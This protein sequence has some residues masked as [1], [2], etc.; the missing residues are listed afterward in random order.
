MLFNLVPGIIAHKEMFENLGFPKHSAMRITSCKGFFLLWACSRVALYLSVENCFVGC[1]LRFFDGP[2]GA[3]IGQRRAKSGTLGVVRHK[4]SFEVL[5]YRHED[6]ILNTGGQ[7]TPLPTG[8]F[9]NKDC[10]SCPQ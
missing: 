4:E 1:K 5:S 9:V 10:S 8:H 3:Y 6:L 2:V 7:L